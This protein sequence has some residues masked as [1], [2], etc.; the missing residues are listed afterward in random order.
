MWNLPLD[1][2]YKTTN[3]F[4]WPRL[5]ITVA[6]IDMFARDVLVGYGSLMVPT[7]PGTYVRTVRLFRP[8]SPT[9]LQQAF[10]WLTGN[11]PEFWDHKIVA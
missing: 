4:G 9:M 8:V 11:H 1:I 5:V 3:V 10:A 2:I 6:S 7:V